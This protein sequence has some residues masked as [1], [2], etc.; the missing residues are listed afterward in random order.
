MNST[1]NTKGC[2]R[3]H[4]H[5][6]P[7]DIFCGSCAYQLVSITV[8]P[9]P[10]EDLGGAPW[11]IFSGIP[12]TLKVKNEGVNPIE[13][14]ELEVQGFEITQWHGNLELPYRLNA[15]ENVELRCSHNAR[16]GS[17]GRLELLSSIS[18]IKPV[19][20]FSRCEKAPE[21]SLFSED[22]HEFEHD[23]DEYQPCAIDPIDGRISLTLRHNSPLR[24]QAAPYLSEGE[25]YFDI[26]GLPLDQE[27]PERLSPEHPLKFSL[28]RRQDFEETCPTVINFSFDS[29]GEIIFKLSLRYVERPKLEWEFSRRFLNDQALV[30][31][32]KQK[33]NLTLTVD[34]LSGP[35]FRITR[36]ESS[37]PWL[38]VNNQI[39]AQEPILNPRSEVNIREEN[40]YF[41]IGLLL[42]QATLPTVEQNTTVEATLDI[43]GSTI[44][45][46]SE[47]F[48]HS[49][50]FPVQT[51]PPQP[52][53]FPIAVDFGTTNSCIAYMDP[54]DQNKEKLLELE[55][56]EDILKILTS[57]IPTVFQFSAI[58]K[59]DDIMEF[60]QELNANDRQVSLKEDKVLFKFGHTPKDLR[61]NPEDIRSISWGFKRNLRTP[62]EQIVYND[63]GT[64]SI[65]LNGRA[66]SQGNRHIEVD[67]IEK[68]G[69]Y[70]R[71]LLESFQE[72]TSYLPTEAVFT[73]PAVF[74]RQKEALRKAIAWATQETDIKPILDIS[75]P[76][77]IA[78]DYAV[79][80]ATK[81]AS[82]RDIVYGVFDCG[83]GTTD[84]SIVRLIPQDYGRPEIEILASDGDDFLGGDLLSFKIARELY[85]QIIPLYKKQFPFPE[86]LDE[87]L[88]LQV[89]IEEHNFSKL[90][91]LAEKI[92]ENSKITPVFEEALQ[93]EIYA[94]YSRDEEKGILDLIKDPKIM[95]NWPR[96]SLKSSENTTLEIKGS[97]KNILQDETRRS[98]IGP[99]D[100]DTIH[101]SVREELEK[102]F[103]KLNQMQEYLFNKKQIDD[104]QLDY[105]ILEGN[106]SR[107]P[108]VKTVAKEKVQAKEIIFE[109]EK[110]KKSVAFGAIKYGRSLR[111]LYYSRPKGIQKLNYPICLSAFTHFVPIFDRWTPLK[112]DTTIT[113]ENP[114]PIIEIERAGSEV[115]LYEFFGWDLNTRV[116]QGESRVIANLI[117][118]NENEVFQNAQFWTYCLELR[119]DAEGKASLWYNYKVGNEKNDSDFEYVWK[120]HRKCENFSYT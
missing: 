80:I 66:Y 115:A 61:F 88:R 58:K 110:L 62:D 63:R 99:L 65:R 56:G 9:D 42:N 53:K 32:G 15:N 40:T 34:H 75:E 7:E 74:N 39:V 119:C 101:N 111:D 44:G 87:A 25:D 93:P 98:D 92:K 22:E 67:A 85:D 112:P 1:G 17:N 104:I 76:E 12:I 70:I 28:T 91:E 103:D 46:D 105:L 55:S 97:T 116:T 68:V 45:D 31:G 23:T 82:N 100:I 38:S 57:E 84:I 83:G 113:P 73:Y 118:P 69:L 36:V 5:I 6:S 86:T 48:Y 60:T 43:Q 49:I 109:P 8:T 20:F 52:L 106:T 102:G 114:G 24:L 13:I 47:T 108:L 89:K 41:E 51:R 72:N 54:R 96:I 14:Q 95:V 120:A 78:L 90:Y 19:Y 79:D 10:D 33:I 107:F 59:F 71:F 64:G 30:S 11:P 77:A 18:S 35:P 16:E 2:P 117:V 29:L 26:S 37:Q 50:S 21:I 94:K 81:L 3:C 4:W 27:F